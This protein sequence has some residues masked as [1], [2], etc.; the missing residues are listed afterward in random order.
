MKTANQFTF[1]TYEA[2]LKL[3][4]SDPTKIIFD[5]IDWSFI[6]RLVKERYKI[7]PKGQMVMTSSLCLRL[8]FSSTWV[9]LALIGH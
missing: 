5:N 6:H 8:S 4:P 2:S 1:A 7:L 9:R 3:N